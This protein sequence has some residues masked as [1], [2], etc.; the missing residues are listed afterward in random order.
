MSDNYIT[1]T[2]VKEVKNP[3]ELSEKILKWLQTKEI[4]ES[5]LSDCILSTKKKGYKPANKHTDA[6]GYNENILS[7]QVC[8]L[9]VKTEREVFNA[10]AFTPFTK[11]EC[12]NCNTNRFKGIS[13]QD[14]YTENCT[15]E[16]L[17]RF[18]TVFPEFD[19]WSNNKDTSLTCPHCLTKSNLASYKTDNSIAFSNLGFTFWN[20]PD[21]KEEF[22]M[23]LKTEIGMDIVR[24]N[25]HL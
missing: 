23:E 25:G 5:E 13:P 11:L 4:I 15:E 16:Q 22:L 20:W 12:P 17:N 6:I 24:M 3:K 14:F 8:G 18:N 21:L 10:G 1:I 9:E 2:T 19:K 7:L